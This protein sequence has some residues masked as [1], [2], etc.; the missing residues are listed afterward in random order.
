[1][2]AVM[3]AMAAGKKVIMD[4]RDILNIIRMI[5]D[6]TDTIRAF[7]NNRFTLP[8]RRGIMMN[9]DQRYDLKAGISAMVTTPVTI[10]T[11]VL[12]GKPINMLNHGKSTDSSRA[13]QAENSN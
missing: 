11:V 9:A 5:M 4:R 12:A 8:D 6:R 2:A 3:V 10:A 13:Q 7:C 1:M